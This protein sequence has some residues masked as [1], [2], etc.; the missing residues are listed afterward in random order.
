MT[1]RWKREFRSYFKTISGWIYIAVLMAVIS[2]YF[3]ANNL[4]Y[5]APQIY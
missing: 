1:A 3:F 4:N 5:G 2:L